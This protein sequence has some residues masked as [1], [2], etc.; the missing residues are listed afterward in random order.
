[1][2]DS[3]SIKKMLRSV[4][5]SSKE[6][7]S[8]HRLQLEYRSLCGENIPLKKLGFINL[9]DYLRDIPSVVRLDY[10]NGDLR[11]FAAV[12]SETAH[13]AQ[14]VARQ[15]SSKKS[16]CSQF[17]NCR[18]RR[19]ASDPY[20]RRG[21]PMSSLRQPSA[22]GTFK[23]TNRFQ[24]HGG[25][26]GFS[27]SGD[28]RQMGQC[29]IPPVEHRH[30]APHPA[31]KQSVIPD[32]PKNLIILQKSEENPPEQVSR[33]NC[34]ESRLYDYD[35]IVVQRRLNQLL[36]KY[37]SGLWMSKLP[38]V[39][40][41]MFSQQLHPQVLKDLEKWTQICMVEKSY[42]AK[43]DRL[44]YPPLLSSIAPRSGLADDSAKSSINLSTISTLTYSQESTSAPLPVDHVPKPTAFSI[45]LPADP[46]LGLSTQPADHA[47]SLK[48]PQKLFHSLAVSS[49]NVNFVTADNL[50]QNGPPLAPTWKCPPK[51]NTCKV[52]SE[53]LPPR[54]SALSSI[55]V[56]C[57]SP[58]VKSCAAL[59]PDDVCYR[60]KELLSKY[61]NGLWV[62]A[63]PKLFIDTYKTPF[64]EHFMNK[65]C[66]LPDLCTVEYPIPNDSKK[67]ILYKSMR[68][69][70]EQTD[71]RDSQKSRSYHLPSGVNVIGPKIPACLVHPSMQYPS[72]LVIDA[73]SSNAV[74]IRYV[75]KDYSEAQEAMEDAMLSFY[76]QNPTLQPLS[77]LAVGQVV[78]VKGEN[79][80][81]LTRAQVTEVTKN[82]I[83]VYYVDHG[84]T[85]ETHRASVLDLH[86]DFLSLPFQ[87]ANVRLAGLEAFSSH[88]SVLSTLEK[89]AVGKILLMEM[90]GSIHHNDL[91]EAL[92]YDTS[93]DEDININSVCLKELQ[94]K[95]M[96]NPL[97]VYST[98]QG[99]CVTNVCA[100]GIVF[101]Q[102][103]SRGT[104]RLSKLLEK[105]K[106][107][108]ISQMTSEY[109]V[110][111]PFHGKMCLT[112]Y[113]DK[114]SRAEITNLHGNRVIEVVLIDL[115][116]PATVEVTELREIPTI[117]IGDLTLI[118][119][120]AI[121][122]RLAD[123]AVPEG[124]WSPDVV[125]YIKDA[126]LGVEDCKMKILKLEEDKGGR[127][128]H[129]YLY[130]DADCEDMHQ[131]INHQLS[132][133]DGWQ[134][135][136]SKKSCTATDNCSAS[137]KRLA[138]N[139]PTHFHPQLCESSSADTTARMPPPLELPLPGQ[140]MDVHIQSACHP[141][142]FVLQPWQDLH[143]LVVLMGEMML[144]YNQ[145]VTTTV[146]EIKKGDIYAAKIDKNWYRAVVKG[147]LSNGLISI[148][149]LDHGKHELLRSAFLQPLIEEFRQLPFQAI[150][151]QLAGVPKCQWSEE[152]SMVFR[153]HVEKQALVAQI[154]SV[155]DESEVK[156]ELW[157]Q[158]ITVYLVDTKVEDK[159]LWIHSFMADIWSQPSS[160]A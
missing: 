72:V 1:M 67:A 13:I 52:S 110:S 59:V 42:S 20:M 145:T 85:V 78:A 18:M 14:L 153:N 61:T 28:V 39:F 151:A 74:T 29:I 15:K 51:N 5:Q 34:S 114:W 115:G 102:L 156:G 147:V 63:L 30:S 157:E 105:T 125:S 97:T 69:N 89:F 21:W 27:A 146:M 73:K 75:G 117:F 37:C 119:P 8:I 154:E 26:R 9:E 53:N 36:K 32:R 130:V 134:T 127:L 48:V 54:K 155:Q 44:V 144:Y 131:S 57:P 87:A 17:V 58:P 66:L 23:L 93:Q 122:C 90:L 3:E 80:N 25:Y 101:C 99:V 12:C 106:A 16:G 148:Y 19:K 140:N 46:A 111:K 116:V 94:D 100:D 64:P 120:Q 77:K 82:N 139:S 160:P 10:N 38:T 49:S 60:I 91:P 136:N 88:P 108:F 138:L 43:G 107:F 70:L 104:P 55:A 2:S 83:T 121:R 11:C 68:V 129:I 158:K 33:T 92:L 71:S 84:F 24:S 35:E 81:E 103:P 7:V 45:K 6:G 109:L 126:V 137:V 62:H 159:D 141:A 152:A 124:D 132:N 118:P 143:K 65:L 50:R 112:C 86:H 149:E 31:V 135:L 96:N 150:T 4:L 76:K 142:Y 95:T 79:G 41:E 133:S 22:G 47:T 128:V 123:V 113:K 98:Y 40:S 56:S